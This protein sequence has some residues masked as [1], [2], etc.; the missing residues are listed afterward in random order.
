MG[1]LGRVAIAGCRLDFG[2]A[3]VEGVAARFPPVPAIS[4]GCE[5]RGAWHGCCTTRA[6]S[7][8]GGRDH[9]A[10][11]DSHLAAS[12]GLRA[13][14][15]R[16]A[17]D[18]ARRDD[19]DLQRHRRRVARAAAV[20]AIGPPRRRAPHDALA[21]R[22]RARRVAGVLLHVSRPQ[23]DV[24]VGRD[25]VL[26]HGHRDRRRRSRRDSSHPRERRVPA[27]A[28]HRA[29]ARPALH[30]G[31]RHARQSA[32]RDAVVRLLAAALRRRARRRRPHADAR[33]RARRDRRRAATDVPV[34]RR[35]GRGADAGA[36]GSGQ[37][38]LDR[39]RRA[40]D[41]AAQGRR[42]AWKTRTP[43]SRA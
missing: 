2:T 31:R 12:A 22:R 32:D 28:A 8:Q 42:D 17:R 7:A 26:Q 36:A 23:H 43:T 20:S 13:R 15:R 37:N 14:D 34:P 39:N 16:H 9:V 11:Y 29:L 25:L 30:G 5:R 19:G 41:R 27:D 21:R 38:V 35:A 10:P 24:R 4:A 6:S 18:R 1:A 33:R 40:P 3:A